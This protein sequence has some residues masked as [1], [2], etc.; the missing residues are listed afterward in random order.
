[1]DSMMLKSRRTRGWGC[2]FARAAKLCLIVDTVMRESQRNSRLLV[3]LPT[4]T[5]Q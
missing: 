4:E 2:A 3:F 1:L 5:S